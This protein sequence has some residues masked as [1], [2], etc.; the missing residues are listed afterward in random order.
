MPNII[1]A[2]IPKVTPKET[3]ITIPMTIP[4]IIPRQIPLTIP[5]VTPLLGLNQ[6]VPLKPQIPQIFRQ[7]NK[8]RRA[9]RRPKNPFFGGWFGRKWPS[10]VDPE[11]L[12][13]LK[14]PRRRR[15]R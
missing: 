7:Y 11:K 1:P 15:K 2:L 5:K 8:K 9:K 12:L 6:K 4:Q 3:L 13:G 14:Q 10:A